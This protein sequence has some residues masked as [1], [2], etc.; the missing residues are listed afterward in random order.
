MNSGK[1]VLLLL[2]GILFVAQSVLLFK[3]KKFLIGT[4]LTAVQGICALLA[5]NLIGTVIDVRIPLN[6][7]S[8]GFFSLFGITGVIMMLFINVLFLAH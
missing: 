4:F 2:F 8:L 6:F 3:N 7:W 1:L 5:V